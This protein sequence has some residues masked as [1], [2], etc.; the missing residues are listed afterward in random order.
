MIPFFLRSGNDSV[1]AIY[2]PP[3]GPSKGTAV[4][5]VPPFGWDDQTSY[6]PRREWSQA[7]AN[8]G[9]PSLRIDLPGTGDSSGSPL[10]DKLVGSWS[11]AVSTAV[12]WLRLAGAT[13]IAVIALGSGGL[14]TLHA[15]ARGAVVED[16]V[17]WGVPGDG[18]S[19][20]RE[21]RAF[22][23]LEQAQASAPAAVES[24]TGL[25]VA[26]HF[27]APATLADLAAL[28]CAE[29]LRAAAPRRALLL[30]RDGIQP[31]ARLAVALADAGAAVALDSGHGWG[32]ML[33]RP[34]SAPPRAV[35]DAVNSWLGETAGRTP[36]LA[37]PE[38]ARSATLQG[39]EGRIRETALPFTTDGQQLHA[40]LSE[41]A[42]RTPA[43]GT[44]IL[45]NAGAIRRIGPNRMWTEAARRWSARG[46]AVLRV[47]LE[48]IGDSTGDGSPYSA[49]D[50]SF[51]TK[52]LVAQARAALALADDRGLPGR[53]VLAGL[54]SG[55]FWAFHAAL[56]DPRVEAVAAFNPRMLIFDPHAEAR[57]DVR[58]LRA[59]V[60]RAGLRS[61][62]CRKDK[63]ARLHRLVR[64]LPGQSLRMV[65]ARSRDDPLS[66]A[67]SAMGRRGQQVHLAFSGDEPLDHE[68]AARP[69]HAALAGMGVQLHRLPSS[70]HTLKPPEAQKAAHEIL[71][72]VVE[73]AFGIAPAPC[74]AMLAVAG[75]GIA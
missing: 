17:M 38:S 14:L 5:L 51:Y 41:P 69:G 10:D 23:R 4:L 30:G 40:V 36:H 35:F 62:L 16:L 37:P 3:A 60:S 59:I 24:G 66:P 26:G 50:E 29:L 18:R 28:D 72:A 33:A 74:D 7:L 12:A 67:L 21:M 53:F 49:G 20:I 54:C 71:D 46:L 6:R 63:L 57:R 61:M 52:E 70:S 42:D 8:A 31:G 39:A 45:Y 15:L 22:A 56:A 48:G 47:D 75:A 25:H 65:T 19:L 64:S 68:L 34:Q 11:A 13:R 1:A 44:L 55:A 2:H 58:R 27:L 32:E 73:N 43:T 9:F